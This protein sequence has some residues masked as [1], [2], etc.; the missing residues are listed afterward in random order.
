MNDTLH[1]A[2]LRILTQCPDGRIWPVGRERLAK[3]ASPLVRGAAAE[4]LGWNRDLPVNRAALLAG[5]RDDYRLGRIR[6]DAAW[7]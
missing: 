1:L 2:T 6:S 7:K 4:L 5:C 3:D